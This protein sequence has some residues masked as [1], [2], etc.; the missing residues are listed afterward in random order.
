MPPFYSPHDFESR[1]NK[2]GRTDDD[3]ITDLPAFP[4][5]FSTA[6]MQDMPRYAA[7]WPRST[8][9]S[10]G[11]ST[12]PHKLEEYHDRLNGPALAGT[13]GLARP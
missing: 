5:N 4:T 3:R 8:F 12:R 7:C 2:G 9:H 11:H 10:L 1:C 6:P 13:N